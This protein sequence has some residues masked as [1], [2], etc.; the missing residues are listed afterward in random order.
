MIIN[1]KIILFKKKILNKNYYFNKLDFTQR[2]VKKQILQLLQPKIHAPITN[3]SNIWLDLKL[4]KRLVIIYV[5]I[6]FTKK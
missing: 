2:I 3:A 5:I 6:L 4:L 1:Y